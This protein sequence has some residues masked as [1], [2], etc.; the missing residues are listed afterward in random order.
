MD[1]VDVL[2]NWITDMVVETEKPFE[3][4]DPSKMEDADLAS[5]LAFNLIPILVE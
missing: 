1:W 5:W 4:Y 3:L 2:F